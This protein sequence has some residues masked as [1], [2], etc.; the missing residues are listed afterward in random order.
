MKGF[1][2]RQIQKS[3]K[4]KDNCV[5]LSTQAVLGGGAI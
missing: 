5:E 4:L 3:S 2:T 1:T